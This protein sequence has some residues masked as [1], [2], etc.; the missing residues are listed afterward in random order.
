L[1][2]TAV[3]VLSGASPGFD[4]SVVTASVCS[5]ALLLPAERI[6]SSGAKHKLL[7]VFVYAGNLL[8]ESGETAIAYIT[9]LEL[10]LSSVT[11]N[12]GTKPDFELTTA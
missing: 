6:S 4:I 1:S 3:E 8:S 12:F 10:R 2:E 11:V 7:I 9:S 5:P